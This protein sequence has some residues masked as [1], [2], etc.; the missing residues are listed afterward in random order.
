MQTKHLCVFV[1]I[2]IKDQFGS[3]KLVF[4][5]PEIFLLT[6]QVRWFKSADL[7]AFLYVMSSCV[8]VTFPFGVL[9]QVWRLTISI[10]DLYLLP[11]FYCCIC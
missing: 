9:G 8:F 4:S 5:T 11:T 6:V 7:L 10:P 1:H 3:V 2:R